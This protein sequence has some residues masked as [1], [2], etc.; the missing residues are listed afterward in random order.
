MELLFRYGTSYLGTFL[1]DSSIEIFYYQICFFFYW[2]KITS[3]QMQRHCT[4]YWVFDVSISTYG[5]LC[6][7]WYVP[8]YFLVNFPAGPQVISILI[9]I[10]VEYYWLTL[11][12]HGNGTIKHSFCVWLFSFIAFFVINIVALIII[13]VRYW[14]VTF[15][16][17]IPWIIHF[18]LGEHLSFF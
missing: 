17:H 8:L 5:T 16:M 11:K 1:Y 18:S 7:L 4:I 10:S 13:H 14:V 9:S 15:C 3:I 6:L 2:G 12:F